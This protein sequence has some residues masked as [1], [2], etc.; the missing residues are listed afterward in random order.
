M[1]FTTRTL[2]ILTIFVGLMLSCI[3][4]SASPVDLHQWKKITGDPNN[5]SGVPDGI[6]PDILP[7]GT[8]TNGRQNSYAWCLEVFNGYLYVGT[9]RNIVGGVFALY[10]HPNP[11]PKDVPVPTDMRGRIF[12][13]KLSTGEWERVYV[14]PPLTTTP[15]I[16]GPDMGYRGMKVFRA[17]CS[18]PVLYVGGAGLGNLSGGGISRL[19][20][21]D[22]TGNV[23]PIFIAQNS[24]SIRAMAVHNGQFFWGTENGKRQV[25][26]YSSDPLKD[27]QHGNSFNKIDVPQEWF[28]DGAQMFDM[29]SYNNALY[30]FFGA[31]DGFWCAKLQNINGQWRWR[32][33]VGDSAKVDPQNPPKYPSGMGRAENGAATPIVFKGQMYVG[34][35]SGTMGRFLATGKVDWDN[36]PPTGAQL[37][38]FGKNDKWERLIP[39]GCIKNPDI[40]ARLNGLGNPLNL[41]FWRF[42]EQNGRLYMGTFDASVALDIF[43][44][45]LSGLDLWDPEGFDLYSTTNGVVWVPEALGGFGDRYNY[46]ARTL[47]TNPDTGDLYLGTANPF[48]GCQIWMKPAKQLRFGR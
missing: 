39:P 10:V 17:A 16:Y 5:Y 45:D 4:A 32:V 21:I 15:V 28:P 2:L 41:Y 27:Y 25:I 48:Y 20:A 30:V 7:D 11:W 13:M 36:I 22:R 34:T 1:K 33:I 42:A 24:H 40:E 46:G 44:L 31:G 3:P 6:L 43:G 18:D 47:F 35:L 19:L 14:A 9:S 8:V 26:W 29:I 23:Q 37:F 38:R 12:R